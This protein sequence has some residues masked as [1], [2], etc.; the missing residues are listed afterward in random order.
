V[1]IY[2]F[3]YIG[4]RFYRSDVNCMHI[5]LPFIVKNVY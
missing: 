3:H 1:S 5:M 2:I 4:V